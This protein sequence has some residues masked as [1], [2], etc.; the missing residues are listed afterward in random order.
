MFDERKIAR[1]NE[2]KRQ[3]RFLFLSLALHFIFFAVAFLSQMIFPGKTDVFVPTVQ[4]D[5]L[6]LPDQVKTPDNDVDVT[7]PV[8]ENAKPE[9]SK[10]EPKDDDSDMKFVEEKPKP[11]KDTEKKALSAIEKLRQE[12][13]KE[14]KRKEEAM[15][16]KRK[17]E[18]KNFEDRYRAPIRGNQVNQG[19]SANGVLAAT[20]NAYAGHVA[21]RV[22][23]N[24]GLPPYLSN[25]NL[26]AEVRIFIDSSGNLARY[27]FITSSGN[28]VFDDYVKTSI[29]RAAPFAPPPAEMARGLRSGGIDLQFPL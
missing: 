21:D 7:K 3:K 24:W 8:K 20:M 14:K 12:I 4:I 22:R 9:T 25:Q 2:W 29:T 15:A 17:D 19:T 11:K 23:R 5:M 1:E 16:Q 10:P 6:A 26:R 27:Q 18:L 13:A 28:Q